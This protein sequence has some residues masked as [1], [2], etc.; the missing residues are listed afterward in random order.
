M[1]EEPMSEPEEIPFKFRTYTKRELA[2]LYSPTLTR[3][4]AIRIFTLWIK[5]N[6]DLYAQLTRTGYHPRTRTFTPRQ[7]RMITDVLD[8]P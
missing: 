7:V 8:I 5:K 3:R 6:K 2:C 4:C 1:K